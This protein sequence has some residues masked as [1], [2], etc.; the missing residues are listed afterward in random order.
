MVDQEH[1]THQL[2]QQHYYNMAE[3]LAYPIG[4]PD[5]DSQVIGTQVGVLQ[6]NGQELNV[7]RN[8][9]VGSILGLLDNQFVIQEFELTTA[10][11]IN[12]FV[13]PKVLV[14]GQPDKIVEVNSVTFQIKNQL[15]G[16]YLDFTGDVLIQTTK[17][18]GW[19]YTIPTTFLNTISSPNAFKAGLTPGQIASGEGIAIDALGIV[20]TVG[21]ATTTA[22]I[23]VT[24]RFLS[25]F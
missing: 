18:T 22:K 7:T 10:E 25:T 9:T 6:P 11:L 19:L 3:I 14:P 1:T 23:S 20:N 15:A 24:Y 12:T 4:Q 17:P 5:R 2:T 16:N 21:T 13:N 8:F